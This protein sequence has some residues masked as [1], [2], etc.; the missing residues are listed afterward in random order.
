MAAMPFAIPHLYVILL[1]FYFYFLLCL[2]SCHAFA[3]L[4]IFII[5]VMR[6]IR[7][8]LFT[9]PFYI[10]SFDPRASNLD[11]HFSCGETK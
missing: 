1:S 11:S 7:H 3:S 10:Y 4:F 5:A 8:S 2:S 9:M 6:D